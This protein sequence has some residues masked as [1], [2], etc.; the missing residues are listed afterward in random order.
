MPVPVV[1]RNNILYRHRT[2][3]VRMAQFHCTP[4]LSNVVLATKG[5]ALSPTRAVWVGTD[6]RKITTEGHMGRQPIPQQWTEEAGDLDGQLLDR[7]IRFTC[8]RNGNERLDYDFLSQYKTQ[9]SLLS[10][11]MQF[12]HKY[13]TVQLILDR[14]GV[15]TPM[16]G[17][18]LPFRLRYLRLLGLVPCSE[19]LCPDFQR[20]ICRLSTC[21]PSA[22]LEDIDTRTQKWRSTIATP[23]WDEELTAHLRRTTTYKLDAVFGIELGMKDGRAYRDRQE[24]KYHGRPWRVAG[25]FVAGLVCLYLLLALG[26]T[27][28]LSPAEALASGPA[29]LDTGYE[30]VNL[31]G[32]TSFFHIGRLGIRLPN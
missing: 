3:K 17:P 27:K 31:P 21:S 25:V 22:K 28:R 19:E 11:F 29:Q 15:V 13:T 12:R 18:L 8:L 26:Y 6:S 4:S 20:L 9:H 23:S 10:F 16:V 1:E 30:C 2:K 7:V 32:S 24:T 14:L 5:P